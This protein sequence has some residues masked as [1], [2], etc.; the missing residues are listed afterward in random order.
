M[1]ERN[2]PRLQILMANYGQPPLEITLKHYPKPVIN[3]EIQ[4]LALDRDYDLFT[5]TWLSSQSNRHSTI[6]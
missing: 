5:L 4:R 6:P 1:A 2:L 3:I